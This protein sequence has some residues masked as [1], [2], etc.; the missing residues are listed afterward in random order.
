[1]A[2]L[3][4]KMARNKYPPQIRDPNKTNSKIGDHT[5]KDTFDSKYKPSFIICK[6]IS[7][8]ASDVQDSTG[9]VRGVSIQHL[10]LLH[11]LEHVLTNL[12]DITSFGCTTKYINHPYLMPDLTTTIKAKNTHA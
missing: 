4:L 8:K 12:L 11:S 9:K 2:A 7:D 10:Q 6:K 3:N 5:P 1:M